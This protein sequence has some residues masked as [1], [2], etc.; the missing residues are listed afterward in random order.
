[1]GYSIAGKDRKPKEPNVEIGPARQYKKGPGAGR[2]GI[3]VTNLDTGRKFRVLGFT[4]DY[5]IEL[6]PGNQDCGLPTDAKG[7]LLVAA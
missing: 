7:R 6:T 1:M 2:P 4:T 3:R 5:K